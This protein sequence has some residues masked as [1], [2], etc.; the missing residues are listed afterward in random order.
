MIQGRGVRGERVL[1]FLHKDP[2]WPLRVYLL[3]FIPS[4]VDMSDCFTSECIIIFTVTIPIVLTAQLIT[5]TPNALM[6]LLL[7]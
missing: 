5:V 7:E 1:L 2:G 6:T 4:A 3:T